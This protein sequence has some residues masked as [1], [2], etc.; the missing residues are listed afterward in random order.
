M[1]LGHIEKFSKIIDK[2]NIQ[3]VC[4][5]STANIFYLTGFYCEP[6]ERLLS[7]LVFPDEEPMLICPEMEVNLAKNSGWKSTIIGY[8]DSQDPWKAIEEELR[9]RNKS[10]E[11][12]AVEE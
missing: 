8:A 1:S 12:I 3:L 11:R 4:L 2:K 7:L 10:I 6:H 9:K 5:T